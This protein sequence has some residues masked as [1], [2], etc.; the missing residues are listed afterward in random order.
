[1]VDVDGAHGMAAAELGAEDLHV[2]SQHQEIYAEFLHDGLD[3]GLLLLLRLG[4]SANDGQML[5]RHPKTLRHI[6]HVGVI[7]DNNW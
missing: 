4:P 6:P 5:K 3:S 2:P 1:M 7:A